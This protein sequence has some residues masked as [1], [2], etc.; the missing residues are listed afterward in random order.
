[1][2]T[3]T[4]WQLEQYILQ[5]LDSG[6]TKLIDQ[7]LT[8][9]ENLLSRVNHIKQS[10]N[11][12]LMQ[13]PVS[14]FL[15]NI[16]QYTS[17]KNK[18]K[19]KESLFSQIINNLYRFINKT[20][21]TTSFMAVLTITFAV[22][23]LPDQIQNTHP[24]GYEYKSSSDSIRVKGLQSSIK[25]YKKQNDP[26]TQDSLLTANEKLQQGDILQL[27]YI[28]GEDMYGYI[29]SIDGNGVLTEHLV[30]NQ[31]AV[32]LDH[33]GEIPLNFAYQL[34]D[35]PVF[36]R[37]ILIS[38]KQIFNTDNIKKESQILINN[39]QSK[40]GELIIQSNTQDFSINS[41]TLNKKGEK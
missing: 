10:N 6:T 21:F 24:A 1:M 8:I 13:L 19:T 18:T 33:N 39:Q 4:D 5:E 2:K 37:F 25:I 38:S 15:S 22:I 17:E 9:D 32:L 11:E 23:I 31:Q 35:A 28:A 34:D 26:N 41:I 27:S 29:F 16:K 20:T 30:D 12:L 40:L 7:Q 36:E 14:E 3:F